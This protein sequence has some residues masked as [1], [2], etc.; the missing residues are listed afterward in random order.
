MPASEDLPAFEE[1]VAELRLLR[2]RGLVR[3]RHT[4]LPFLR[5]IAA[6][7]VAGGPAGVEALLRA[8]VENLTGTDLGSSAAATFGLNRGARDRPAQT[9]RQ[10]AA[11]VYNVSTERFRKYHERI[12]IEHVADEI[13]K[14]ATARTVPADPQLPR[15]DVTSETVLDG[16]IGGIHLPLVVHVEPVELITGVS[17]VVVPTNVYMALPPH[18]KLSVSAAVRR[19]AAI[20]SPDGGIVRDVVAEEISDWMSKYGRTGLA[21]APGTIVPTSAGE[22]ETRGVR[23]LYHVAVTAPRPG[24]NDYDVEPTAIAACV[25]NV[26]GTARG[27]REEYEPPLA[28]IGFPLL[29]AGHGGLDPAVSFDWIWSTLARDISE[30][31]PWDIH[32]ISRHQA[33]ADVIIRRLAELGVIDGGQAADGP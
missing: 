33:V 24:T 26:L 20:R 17:I 16:R 22:M 31:G 10:S 21:V 32:F 14:L 7:A 25:R 19:A 15:P 6:R 9:R 29:G 27:E 13:L 2:E 8:A 5:R 30:R 28:S 18:F 4:E 23:R 11:L 3:I 12:V 1:I